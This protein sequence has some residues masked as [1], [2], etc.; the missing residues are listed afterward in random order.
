M[1]LFVCKSE[2]KTYFNYGN[3]KNTLGSITVFI[4]WKHSESFGYFSIANTLEDSKV[5]NR[6]LLN[7]FL[8]QF[9]LFINLLL[10]I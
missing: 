1:I 10:H 7:L 5:E 6:I 4:C 3:K 8:F 9:Y 2:M